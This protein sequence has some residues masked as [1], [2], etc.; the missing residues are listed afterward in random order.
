MDGSSYTLLND[1]GIV[2]EAGSLGGPV[3]AALGFD[4]HP[5]KTAASPG[6]VVAF[7]VA[8]PREAARGLAGNLNTSLDNN[9][10][11]IHLQLSGT[12]PSRAT[13]TLNAVMHQYI[14]V[15]ADLKREK[16][17]ALT[18]ILKEQLASS[19]ED[20]RA[21]E[22]SLEAFQVQTITLPSEETSP[23]VPG[24]QQTT[25]TVLSEFFSLRMEQE[26]LRLDR[27]RL[28]AA[29]SQARAGPL[30]VES[31]EMI[32]RVRESSE[33]VRALGDLTEARAELRA[34]RERYTD[35]YG[36]V[37][38]LIRRVQTLESATIPNLGESLLTQLRAE[39]TAKAKLIDSRADELTE[40]PPRAIEEA[41]RRRNYQI[42]N[43]LYVDLQRR[44]AEAQL[45]AASSIP[46][47]SILDRAT[48]SRN[49]QGTAAFNSPVWPS[50]RFSAWDS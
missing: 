17:D 28:E 34:L 11:F 45:A 3:G 26:V 50:W 2:V 25:N 19:Q 41:R 15:A 31:F 42:A 47:L 48:V 20:L 13:A 39:E 37:A 23:V 44:S 22:Q 24:L 30:A 36:P 35:E 29:L 5:P 38:E 4:W 8:T 49:P 33:L 9:G 14:E 21:A 6:Q 18:S 1:Q 40:I 27:E 46:D 43:D 16:L 10:N 12:N 7:S 32:P